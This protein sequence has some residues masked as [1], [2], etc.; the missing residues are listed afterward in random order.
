MRP[1]RPRRAVRSRETYPP[2]AETSR[3]RRSWFLLGNCFRACRTVDCHNAE[4]RLGV[5]G[6]G[7]SE[8]CRNDEWGCPLGAGRRVSEYEF[9]YSRNAVTLLLLAR[10]TFHIALRR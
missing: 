9:L 5:R 1:L 7:G 10:I 3:T 4:R 6:S 2:L 8:V